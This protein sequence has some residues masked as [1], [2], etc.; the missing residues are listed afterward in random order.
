[1]ILKVFYTKKIRNQEKKLTW[2]SFGFEFMRFEADHGNSLQALF[3]QLTR[4]QICHIMTI[5]DIPRFFEI[6]SLFSIYLPLY[7]STETILSS[8]NALQ[9]TLDQ[10][11]TFASDEIKGWEDLLIKLITTV[12]FL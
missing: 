12:T 4:I 6:N 8:V 2:I 10:T 7:T 9:G 5:E 11:E 1:M 3:T